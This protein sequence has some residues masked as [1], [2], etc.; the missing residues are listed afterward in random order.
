MEQ[1]LSA[2][3]E[4]ATRVSAKA[5]QSSQQCDRCA[6]HQCNV[7]EVQAALATANART[8]EL[9]EQVALMT[10]KATSAGKLGY[11]A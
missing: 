2:E 4:L 9:E 7:A 1:Q 8:K 11:V 6:S 5:D 3:N 10:F